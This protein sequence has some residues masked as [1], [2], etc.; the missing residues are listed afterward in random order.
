MVLAGAV[1]HR[2]YAGEGVHEHL[3]TFQDGYKLNRQR[4]GA[5]Q[6]VIVHSLH[7]P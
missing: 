6:I 5:L 1:G 3:H 7:Q 4:M 2:E